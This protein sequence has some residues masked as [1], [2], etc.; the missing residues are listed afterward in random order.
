ML[1][2][3]KYSII[4]AARD[5]DFMLST[6]LVAIVMGTVMYF[7]TSTILESIEEGSFEM[8]I[9]VVLTDGHE[10]SNFL[11]L[12]R[13]YGMFVYVVTDMDNALDKLDANQIDGIYEIGYA[14]ELIVT[15]SYIR[16]QMMKMIADEYIVASHALSKIAMLNPLGLESAINEMTQS[17]TIL[18]EMAI[19]D[20]ITDQMQLST[21]LFIVMTTLSGIFLGFERGMLTGNDGKVA[22]RRIASSFGKLRLLI[23]DLIG[24]SIMVLLMTFVTWGYFS[25]ILGVELQM[26]LFLAGLAFFITGL[27]GVSLGAFTALIAP[28][29]RKTREQI[30]NGF[31]SVLTMVAF[32][33]SVFRN[34]VLQALNNINPMSML[35]DA[36]TALSFG[37]YNRYFGFMSGIAI[38]TITFLVLIIVSLRRNRNVD[39]D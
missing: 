2:S 17:N 16:Q 25:L 8:P 19:T 29:T 3:I 33:G 35:L 23:S 36:L 7:M 28:G 9:A 5:K 32:V 12:I 10:N 21:I 13:N 24:V 31:Y 37:N 30:L 18:T 14:P 4:R 22:S 1:N 15:R 11:E 39:T 34:D 6:I 27:F 26:N 20:E 38:A